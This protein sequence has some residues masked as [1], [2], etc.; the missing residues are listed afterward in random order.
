MSGGMNKTYWENELRS[1]E[2]AYR[3][4]RGYK[5]LYCPW[6]TLDGH[7]LVFLSLNPGART[8]RGSDP[9]EQLVSDERGNSYEIDQS[10]SRSPMSD[11]FLRLCKFM[12]VEPAEVLTGV[13]APF[14]SVSWEALTDLQQ[15]A[16]MDLGRRFWNRALRSSP[17]DAAIIV[18]SAKATKLVVSLLDAT[19]EKD[20]PSGWGTCLIRRYRTQEGRPIVG[21]PH[22]SRFKLF[23]RAECRPFLKKALGCRAAHERK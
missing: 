7:K 8:P 15:Q 20:M 10:N 17:R 16:S 22:L 5:L 1:T 12:Q 3:F 2:A 13:V 18:C 4:E 21:L 6:K 9:M 23:A 19:L 11:Q 14:R